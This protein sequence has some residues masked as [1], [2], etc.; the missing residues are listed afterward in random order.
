L[1]RQRRRQVGDV[2]KMV[3]Q[4]AWEGAPNRANR[5]VP[6]LVSVCTLW[7]TILAYPED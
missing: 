5:D 7:E 2:Y 4:P 3:G 1:Q 6:A